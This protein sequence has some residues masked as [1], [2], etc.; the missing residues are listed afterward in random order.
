MLECWN[1][2]PVSR[3]TFSDLVKDLEALL[4]NASEVVSSLLAILN[5]NCAISF[6]S[7]MTFVP[8]NVYYKSCG[9][10]LK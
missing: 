7:K 10:K 6:A 5:M 1:A 2:D 9:F 4:V 8:L 3:P